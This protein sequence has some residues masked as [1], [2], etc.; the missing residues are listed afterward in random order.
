MYEKK[1]AFK[2][3]TSLNLDSSLRLQ[4]T[5]VQ[6]VSHTDDNN[7]QDRLATMCKTM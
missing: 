5:S 4:S 2:L 3:E 1:Y 6:N 7:T